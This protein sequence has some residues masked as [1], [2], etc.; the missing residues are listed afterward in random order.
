MSTQSLSQLIKLLVEYLTYKNVHYFLK[1]DIDSHYF[2]V[3]IQ[4]QM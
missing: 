4:N 3:I 2:T 1:L